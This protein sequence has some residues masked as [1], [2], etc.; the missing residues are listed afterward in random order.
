MTFCLENRGLASAPSCPARVGCP[1]L[2][3]VHRWSWRHQSAASHEGL[4]L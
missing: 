2:G 3:G 4:T 1:Q